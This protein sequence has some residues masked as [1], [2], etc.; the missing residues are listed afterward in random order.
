MIDFCSSVQ[1]LLN[2]PERSPRSFQVCMFDAFP[3]S[4]SS[5][6]EVL[7]NTSSVVMSRKV[8]SVYL[9][10]ACVKTFEYLFPGTYTCDLCY[11]S[12]ICLRPLPV[13]QQSLLPTCPEL[14]PVSCW[15]FLLTHLDILPISWWSLVCTCPGLL[16]AWPRS[17]LPILEHTLFLSAVSCSH[18]EC[19]WGLQAGSPLSLAGNTRQ[20]LRLCALP[21]LG[22][23]F[24]WGHRGSTNSVTLWLPVD[25]VAIDSCYPYPETPRFLLCSTGHL[26]GKSPRSQFLLHAACH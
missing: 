14:L 10:V 2:S 16:S 18:S 13:S 7:S 24:H 12:D 21:S 26:G 20:F 11:S 19:K 5:W 17:C 1:P 23:T 8:C 3:F 25:D 15:S 4:A 22:T 9:G 6:W